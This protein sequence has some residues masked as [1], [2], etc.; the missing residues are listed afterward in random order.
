M[1]IGK[2]LVEYLFI[3]CANTAV[4]KEMRMMI[5]TVYSLVYDWT[6]NQFFESPYSGNMY[7]TKLDVITSVEISVTVLY[8][9]QNV[10]CTTMD[11]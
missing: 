10:Q 11:Y 7:S 3:F 6:F 5:Y 8:C 9:I 4:S 2:C 1:E